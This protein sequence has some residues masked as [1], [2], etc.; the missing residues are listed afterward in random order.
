[1]PSLLCSIS[2]AVVGVLKASLEHMEDEADLDGPPSL[3]SFRNPVSTRLVF[4]APYLEK[5]LQ[6]FYRHTSR[7][8]A[9]LYYLFGTDGSKTEL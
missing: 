1:M 9:E 5:F 2:G 3:F 4:I 8:S 7:C 6:Y